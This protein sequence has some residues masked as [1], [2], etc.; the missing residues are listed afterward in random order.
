MF[1]NRF[2]AG[3]KLAKRLKGEFARQVWK[4]TLLLAIPRG[5]VAVGSKISRAL[6][7]QL[8][9]L[10]I[11]KIPAPD[12]P[13]LAI[14]AIGEGGVVVWEEELLDKLK[15]SREYQQA[16]VKE[17]IVELEKKNTD[18]R[19]NKAIPEIGGKTVIVVDDGVATGAT[20]KAAVKVVKNYFPREIIVAVPV[21]ALDSLGEIKEA[22]D[23][24]IY[25]EAPEMFF[26]VG[27]FYEDF[28]QLSDE[29][30]R[31]ILKIK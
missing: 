3:E 2:E 20:I 22:A 1:K 29:E 28:S 4:E 9:I 13:E 19:E 18:F 27:Q 16:I 12:N 26:S 31:E 11:K 21:I 7:C 10:A 8:D 25:L 6:G 24:V 5:G 17:K 15:V 14:G 23:K 30:V